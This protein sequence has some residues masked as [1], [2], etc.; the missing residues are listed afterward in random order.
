MPVIIIFYMNNIE[1]RL[2]EAYRLQLGT[3]SHIHV[4]DNIFSQSVIIFNYE[5]DRNI[6]YLP[7]ALTLTNYYNMLHC[8]T[9]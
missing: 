2:L 8:V 3:L 5:T 7:A 4:A 9:L 1:T 6:P